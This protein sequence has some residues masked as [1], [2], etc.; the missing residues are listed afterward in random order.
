MNRKRK[1]RLTL[2]LLLGCFAILSCDSSNRAEPA[3]NKSHASQ[4]TDITERAN[5]HFIHQMGE[6]GS[7]Y[8]PEI[9]GAG[10]GFLD[11]DNDGDLDVY[12][13]SGAERGTNSHPL[14]NRLFR[15]RGDGTFEDV[16]EA[17]GLGDPGYGMGVAAGDIDN[18]GDVD[19]YVT[20]VGRDALYR[21]NGDGTFTDISQ[22]AGVANDK[23]GS[24]AVFFD[25][26]LD[27]FLDI[28]VANYVLL[29]TT[30]T[31]TDAGGRQDYC[32]PPFY[33]GVADVL[34]HNNGDGTFSDVSGTSGIAMGSSK[35][36]GV[37]SVDVNGDVYPDIYV[38]NDGE[39]NHLWINQHDGTFGDRALEMGAA[40][41]SLGRA[42]A[43]M[44]LALGDVDNDGEADLFVSH[45]KGESNTLYRRGEY[46]FE[47]DTFAAGLAGPSIPYTGFGT[48]LVDFDQ[49]GDQDI[50]LVNGRVLRGPMMALGAGSDYWDPFAEPNKVFE[51]DGNGHFSDVSANLPAFS[52]DV[53]NSR[54]LAAGDVDNDGDVDFL[55]TNGGGEVRLFRNDSPSDRHWLTVRAL[56]PE[57]NRVA[58]GAVVTVSLGEKRLYRYVTRGYSYLSTNDPRVHF[59]LGSATSIDSIVVRWP[60]GMRE[61]FT[62]AGVDRIVTLERGRGTKLDV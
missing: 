21:N 18:D 14:R 46:A 17:S 41:N 25:L 33:A 57:L 55:V 11:Y 9:I 26:D 54:G 2:Q 56:I 48:V 62:V 50:L 31:C 19:V 1:A 20:N 39:P 7:Y 24:S 52:E 32:G 5:L 10:G 30:V 8:Y 22:R 42:E 51:N 16:T 60:D 6:L 15:Q 27:G 38:A 61:S 36:L 49:D 35:G 53:S 44:G 12:V 59:G 29:D 23:W 4:L 34:L 45:L 43:G 13:V 28:Y 3:S 40:V 58:I 47:D 37:V